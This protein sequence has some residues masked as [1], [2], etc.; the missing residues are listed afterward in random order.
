MDICR[1]NGDMMKKGL[2]LV[3]DYSNHVKEFSLIQDFFEKLKLDV[4]LVDFRDISVL[5]E[6]DF[7]GKIFIKGEK[8]DLPDFVIIATVAER[9]VYK[10]RS[11][12]RMF[13]TL[14]VKCINTID[15]I[16]KTGDK[17]YSFQLAKQFVPEVKI[18]KTLL[19]SPEVSL[20][21]IEKEIGFPLVIK[22][23]DGNQGN[24]VCLIETKEELDDMLNIIMASEYGQEI[25]VQ[26]A[27]LSSKGRDIRVVVANGEVIHSFVRYNDNDFKSNIHKGGT[28]DEF[29]APDS[30]ID[31]SVKLAKCFDLKMGSIDFLFGQKEDEFYLC[32]LNSIP[33]ISYIFEAKKNGDVDLIEKFINTIMKLT[34]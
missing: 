13:E 20:D 34:Q 18:P 7:D 15:A 12:V 32:E 25:I 2:F 28:I 33:G 23:M 24:G 26:E 29:N 8:R 22:I 6:D 5:A 27:I 19:V 3:G 17:I 30:L 4:D 21:M 14:N 10:L 11:V 9:N 1:L 31:I 16:D